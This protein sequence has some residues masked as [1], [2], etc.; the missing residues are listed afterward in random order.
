MA[1]GLGAVLLWSTVA[2]A[3]KLSLAHLTPAQ[4][5]LHAAAVSAIFLGALLAVQGK[6]HL[7]GRQWRQAP[8]TYLLGGILNPAAYYLVL[9]AAY[10]ALPA[11][12]AQSLNYTWAIT[13]S[14]LAV[15]LL[16]QKL[17]SW[18]LLAA[19]LAYGG[20]VVIAT[21]G[22]LSQLE[23]EH[24]VGVGLALLSTLLWSL[25][26][27]VNTRDKGE[28]VVSLMLNFLVGL[29][30]ILAVCAWRGEL[31][32]PSLQGLAGA[33]YVGLF[34]MGITFVLWLMA[35][36]SAERT[37]PLSNLIFLSPFLSLYFISTVLGE[38]IAAATVIGLVSIV[39]GLLLQQLGPKLSSRKPQLE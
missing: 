7:L 22:D 1:L 12:Q 5:L 33:A 36:R 18:D 24:P 34:E 38:P 6:L 35:M 9:F 14:L 2:T 8:R 21:G 11:Q 10:D 39:A 19:A 23:F 15:P 26:W 17:K 16:G 32:L 31:S 28:P 13:L 30:V 3:F 29:P 37:A 20:V 27:I 25:Y 4:L